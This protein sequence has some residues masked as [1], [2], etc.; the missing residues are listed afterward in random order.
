MMYL[1]RDRK[2]GERFVASVDQADGRVC[3][4]PCAS[5]ES[6]PATEQELAAWSGDWEVSDIQWS[7]L[8]GGVVI[9]MYVKWH[10][11]EEG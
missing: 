11:A 9:E 8:R 5:G 7:D 2:T 3:T 4:L 10:T 1:L 6:L